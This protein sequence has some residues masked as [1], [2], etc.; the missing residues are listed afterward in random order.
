MGFAQAPAEKRR[1]E[2]RSW[3]GTKAGEGFLGRE[4]LVLNSARMFHATPER[5]IRM[6]TQCGL[7]LETYFRHQELDLRGDIVDSAHRFD[8]V[9]GK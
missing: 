8:Y 7:K 9:F 2:T 3:H 5:L 4:S 1:M 6:A